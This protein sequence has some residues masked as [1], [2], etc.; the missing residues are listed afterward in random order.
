M[1]MSDE[2]PQPSVMC[3]DHMSPK[4]EVRELRRTIE[5]MRANHEAVQ[6]QMLQKVEEKL[7]AYRVR[8]EDEIDKYRAEARKAQERL[9]ALQK[10]A[11]QEP[12]VGGHVQEK[13]F[14]EMADTLLDVLLSLQDKADPL[15][16]ATLHANITMAVKKT[17][18]KILSSHEAHIRCIEETHEQTIDRLKRESLP[19]TETCPDISP[20]LKKMRRECSIARDD[21]EEERQ[22]VAMVCIHMKDSLERKNTQFERAVM[23]KADD[24][25]RQ[26]KHRAEE[27]E[28]RLESLVPPKRMPTVTTSAQTEPEPAPQSYL[29]NAV[30][31]S[32]RREHG[33]ERAEHLATL[34]FERDV[35]NKAQTL[36]QKYSHVVNR[37]RSSSGT[38]TLSA[39][40]APK[41]LPASM[42]AICNY[43]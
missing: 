29:A 39:P 9:A 7:A 22:R 34:Q 35:M 28:R 42:A 1:M 30:T 11:L 18:G 41:T 15:D 40:R 8:T 10:V 20:E 5:E 21:L 27:A 4:D 31:A 6:A 33:I 17:F 25:V 12:G 2:S 32:Y 13:K 3:Y 38:T 16:P 43:P 36:L 24:L 37:E 14:T 19:I 26:Y 23:T